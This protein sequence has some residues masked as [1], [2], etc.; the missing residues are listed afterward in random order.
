VVLCKFSLSWGGNGPFGLQEGPPVKRSSFNSLETRESD[1]D[2]DLLP[3]SAV[4]ELNILSVSYLY[5]SLTCIAI[6]CQ[7]TRSMRQ[8][9]ISIEPC[10]LVVLFLY[11]YHMRNRNEFE[12]ERAMAMLHYFSL[13]ILP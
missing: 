1:C 2:L 11:F 7:R 6:I 3:R 5:L 13:S 4:A 8:R 10:I 9:R 12:R